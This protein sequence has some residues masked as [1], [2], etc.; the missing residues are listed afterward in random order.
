MRF[1]QRHA[2]R[3]LGV[4]QID[5]RVSTIGHVDLGCFSPRGQFMAETLFHHD[6][7]PLVVHRVGVVQSHRTQ[8]GHAAGAVDSVDQVPGGQVEVDT[9]RHLA[10][11]RAGNDRAIGAEAVLGQ[12]GSEFDSPVEVGA[13]H[14]HTVVGQNVALAFEPL[15]ALGADTH[16]REVGGAAADVGDQHDLLFADAAFIVERGRDRLVLE[17]HFVEADQRGSGFESGLRLRV[18]HR[19]VVDE[20]DRAAEHG[21][22]DR[23]LRLRFGAVLQVLEVAGHDVDVFHTAATAHVGGLLDQAAAENAFHRAHQAAVEAVHI[24]RHGGPAEGARRAV[25]LGAFDEIE[26]G[27]RHRRVARLELDEA[28]AG[29][30]VGHGDGRVRGAEVDGAVHGEG[31]ARQSRAGEEAGARFY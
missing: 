24:G 31:P 17:V 10:R 3:A 28:H 6:H 5:A 4:A 13:G 19:I 15:C 2:Q 14:V 12:D 29:G 22:P 9:A 25:E 20:E 11:R 8:L 7:Q 1:A 21:A 18:A 23:R 26:H 27:C 16:D 30:T